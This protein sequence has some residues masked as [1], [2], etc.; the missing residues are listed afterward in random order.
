MCY[1]AT[2]GAKFKWKSR[3]IGMHQSFYLNLDSQPDFLRTLQKAS[4]KHMLIGRATVV[5]PRFGINPLNH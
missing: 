2:A 5:P 4:Y 1:E 3:C